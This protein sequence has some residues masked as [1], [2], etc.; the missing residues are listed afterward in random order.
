ML[1]HRGITH[2]F[3][4]ACVLGVLVALVFF[5]D[6]PFFSA[7]WL[8]LASYFFV[9]TASHALLD[10]LTN[11][12]LGVALLAPFSND[13]YFFPWRPIQVSPIGIGFFS[14][15]GWRV[16]LSELKWIWLPSGML[17]LLSILLRRRAG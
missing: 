7:H 4:F 9:V 15:R 5:R 13:R 12:G 6:V 3:S 16:M 11:G 2:S 10:A 14:E 1:G 8:L 17:F